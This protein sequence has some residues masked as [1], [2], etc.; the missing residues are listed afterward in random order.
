MPPYERYTF[1]SEQLDQYFDR[2]AFPTT[3]RDKDV[4][5]LDAES[6]L[7]YL[8]KL[9]KHQITRV[10]FENLTQHYSWHRVIN[11]HPLHLHRKIMTQPGRGGY[12]MEANS[13]FHNFL[14]SIGFHCYL[15]AGRVHVPTEERWTGWSHL[16]NI[17]VIG[18]TKYLVDVGFGPNEP[19]IPIPLSHGEVRPQ[20]PPAESRVM[21]ETLEENTSGC[22]LW[23]MRHR[24]RPEEEWKTMYCFSDVEI[25]PGD[26]EGLNFAPWASRTSHF[27]QKIICVR[28]T[29]AK[30]SMEDID[31]LP[32]SETVEGGDVDG[33]LVINQDKLSWRR[34]GDSVLEV[35][36]KSEDDRLEA[37]KKYWGIVL[38][39]E[40][41]MAIVGTVSALGQ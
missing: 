14:R 39:V 8:A 4:S 18:G 10:P 28:F 6:Q 31:G 34:R 11:L 38:D 21:F 24:A 41:Q 32:S 29:T 36:L 26:L 40:D 5:A 9:Q 30:E 7:S 12:C 17:V 20:E 37:L 3:Q 25:L 27:T 22:K 1:N 23:L 15:V 35:E 16:V 13:T 33:Q 19:T 2:I